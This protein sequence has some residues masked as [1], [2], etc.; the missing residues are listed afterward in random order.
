MA[1]TC[2]GDML[3]HRSNTTPAAVA[4]SVGGRGLVLAGGPILRLATEIQDLHEPVFANH[5]FSGSV[6]VDVP[7]SCPGEPVGDRRPE[8]KAGLTGV[9]PSRGS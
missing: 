3:P 2:S 4:V 9:V 5:P 1:Q 6:P 8:L 7:A